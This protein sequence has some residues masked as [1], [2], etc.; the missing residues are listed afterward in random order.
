MSNKKVSELP[1]SE[2]FKEYVYA[3]QARGIEMAQ[4]DIHALDAM[5]LALVEEV[6]KLKLK[7]KNS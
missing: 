6:M 5:L 1:V 4:D 7:E 3:L 2:K